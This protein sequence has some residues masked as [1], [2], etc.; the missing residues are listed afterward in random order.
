[1]EIQFDIKQ[2]TAD[3]L[4]NIDDFTRYIDAL[5]ERHHLKKLQDGVYEG[6][7]S[8]HDFAHFGKVILKLKKE[9]WFMKYVSKWL[10]YT[11]DSVEDILLHYQSKAASL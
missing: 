5:F 8:E 7:H 2:V 4:Y 10:F 11:G 9:A 1:M 6:S 3:W